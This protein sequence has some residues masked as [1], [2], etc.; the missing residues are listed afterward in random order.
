[1]SYVG[2]LIALMNTLR[3]FAFSR[4]G[5]GSSVFFVTVEGAPIP[6]NGSYG[7]PGKDGGKGGILFMPGGKGIP[8][9]N[10]G[11]GINPGMPPGGGNGIKGG[12]GILA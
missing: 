5:F 3:K 6:P 4:C 8:E 12:G 7:I 11:G 10:G 9:I 1:L 2:P